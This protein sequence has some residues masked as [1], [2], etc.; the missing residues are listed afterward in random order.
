MM[1][2]VNEDHV[3]NINY[4][5]TEKAHFTILDWSIPKK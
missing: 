1:W 4:G 3:M 2:L 5:L